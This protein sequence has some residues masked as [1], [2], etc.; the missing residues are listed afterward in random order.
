MKK[1]YRRECVHLYDKR[2]IFFQTM[3]SKTFFS[4]C[5]KRTLTLWYIICPK[6]SYC[7]TLQW[8]PLLPHPLVLWNWFTVHSITQPI[9]N[10]WITTLSPLGYSLLRSTSLPKSYSKI[11]FKLQYC[12]SIVISVWLDFGSNYVYICVYVC[13]CECVFY[14]IF[15]KSINWETKQ[16][17]CSGYW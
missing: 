5:S 1:F 3:H 10:Q 4:R 13:V 14:T 15:S 6:K 7:I 16:A 17:V 11:Q 2:A 12:I 9:T 8:T